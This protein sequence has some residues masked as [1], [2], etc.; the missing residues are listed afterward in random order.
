MHHHT[1]SQQHKRNSQNSSDTFVKPEQEASFNIGNRN[2]WVDRTT[3]NHEYLS[4]SY[5]SEQ[6]SL[7]DSHIK[8][9]LAEAPDLL[10]EIQEIKEEAQS[11]DVKYEPIENEE[12]IQHLTSSFVYEINELDDTP[13][14]FLDPSGPTLVS[15]T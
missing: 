8:Q 7:N 10:Y 15:F 3:I 6:M 5:D 13:G 12:I 9:E 11:D 4:A 1:A 2:S 14:K